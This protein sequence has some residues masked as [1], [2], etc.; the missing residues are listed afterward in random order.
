MRLFGEMECPDPR[1]LRVVRNLGVGF[2]AAGGAI[3]TSVDVLPVG[4]VNLA[5][6]VMVVGM[7][8]SIVCQALIK[9]GEDPDEGSAGALAGPGPNPLLDPNR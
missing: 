3:L 4:V 1:I 8:I 5:G 9:D 7:V 2:T 6:Y